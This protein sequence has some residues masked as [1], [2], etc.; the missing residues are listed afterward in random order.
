M[1]YYLWKAILYERLRIRVSLVVCIGRLV[2]LLLWPHDFLGLISANNKVYVEY[3][4]YNFNALINEFPCL[5]IV[6]REPDLFL[7]GTKQ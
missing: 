1:L 2:L 4:V 6:F 5:V 3:S 7:F